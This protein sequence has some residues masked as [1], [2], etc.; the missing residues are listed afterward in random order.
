MLS[1][2]AMRTIVAM[3]IGIA[4]AGCTGDSG[5]SDA[6]VNETVE[7]RDLAA[8]LASVVAVHRSCSVD[9]DCHWVADGCLQMCATFVDGDGVAA[10]QSIIAQASAAQCNAGCQCLAQKAVCDRGVCGPFRAEADGGP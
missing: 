9:A 10:A 7:C 6:S 4:L 5:T 3:V 8:E 2:A 1:E